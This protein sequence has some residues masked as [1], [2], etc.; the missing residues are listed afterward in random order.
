MNVCR[1]HQHDKYTQL[2][3]GGYRLFQL[4]HAVPNILR[5]KVRGLAAGGVLLKTQEWS[6]FF[7]PKGM[8]FIPYLKIEYGFHLK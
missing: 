5:A 2:N 6:T 1:G 3:S 4:L 7:I 8:S